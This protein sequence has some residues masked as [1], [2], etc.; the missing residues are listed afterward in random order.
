MSIAKSNHNNSQ[1]S[2]ENS[3]HEAMSKEDNRPTELRMN[4]RN[5][6]TNSAKTYESQQPNSAPQNTSNMQNLLNPALI[7]I[8]NNLMMNMQN[9][10]ANNSYSNVVERGN[11]ANNPYQTFYTESKQNSHYRTAINSDQPTQST[12]SNYIQTINTQIQVQH[13]FQLKLQKL[14]HPSKRDQMMQT[15]R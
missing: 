9:N 3:E 11:T 15:K 1:L 2:N 4:T 5:S 13:K 7:P 8:I 12:E 10:D 14:F 6:K